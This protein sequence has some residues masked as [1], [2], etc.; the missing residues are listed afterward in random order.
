MKNIQNVSKEI[1]ELFHA[2]CTTRK[3]ILHITGYISK[4]KYVPVGVYKKMVT[5]SQ[6]CTTYPHTLSFAI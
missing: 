3:H 2:K 1:A 4:L 5:T 6:V